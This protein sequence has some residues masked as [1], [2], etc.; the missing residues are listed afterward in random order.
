VFSSFWA[1]LV[2]LLSKAF[3]FFVALI[4][5]WKGKQAERTKQELGTVKKE[6]EY[7]EIEHKERDDIK[8]MK[9]G[10]W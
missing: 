7:L 8:R 2:G 1:G 5:Y 10:T 3:P 4:A 6:K 9:D